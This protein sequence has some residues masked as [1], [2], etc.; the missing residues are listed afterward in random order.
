LLSEAQ[1]Q[2][3]SEARA[4]LDQYTDIE[5]INA[6]PRGSDE[7]KA[8]QEALNTLGFDVSSVDGIV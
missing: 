3:E 8:V 4:T 2:A 5:A 1:E 6:L 7:A